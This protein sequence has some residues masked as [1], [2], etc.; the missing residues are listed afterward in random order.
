ML[1]ASN[2]P[3][4]W[5]LNGGTFGGE[6]YS[7]LDQIN[8]VNVGRLQPAW[9][10]EYDTTRGQEAEPIVVD[11]VMY[12]STSWSKVYALDAATGRQL[13]FYD[14]EVA[15]ADGA[16]ACCDVVNRGVAVY[17]GKVFVGALDGRLIALDARTGKV[18]WSTMT[19]DPESMQTI[20]GAPRVVRGKVIIGNAGADF[21]V[22]GHVSAYDAATGK[23]AWRFYLV[24]GDPEKA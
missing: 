1:A 23:L 22:R 20:T 21:G 10:F 13:W 12:V 5:L 9:Y 24:P 2:E 15:G 6:R 4:N 16:K 8:T 14:P 18:V 7:L 3:E 11:G 19:I 17:E